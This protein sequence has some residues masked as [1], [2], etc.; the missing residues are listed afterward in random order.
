[1]ANH[2]LSGN[3]A[4]CRGTLGCVLHHGGTQ[5]ASCELPDWRIPEQWFLAHF[6]AA[7]LTHCLPVGVSDLLQSAKSLLLWRATVDEDGQYS[8]AIAL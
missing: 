6:S 7:V 3:P 8:F 5:R 4:G 1:M 2:K